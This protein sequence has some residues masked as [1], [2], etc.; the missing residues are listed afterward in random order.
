[1]SNTDTVPHAAG[2]PDAAVPAPSLQL[3]AEERAAIERAREDFAAG[4]TYSISEARAL[5]ARYLAKLRQVTTP[6]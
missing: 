2:P 1:M 5:T 4:R 6:E 3:T